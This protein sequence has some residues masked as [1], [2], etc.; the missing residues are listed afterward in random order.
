MAINTH[1][2]IISLNVNG[3]NAPFKRHRMGDWIKKK[4]TK[5]NRESTGKQGLK[6]R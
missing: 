1:S 3:L 5:K 4:G 2:S 6:W